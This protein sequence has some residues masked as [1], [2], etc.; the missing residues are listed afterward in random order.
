MSEDVVRFILGAIMLAA[1]GGI[2]IWD[3]KLERKERRQREE[4]QN[5][6]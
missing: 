5:D 3:A 4:Q 2:I 6:G 1:I